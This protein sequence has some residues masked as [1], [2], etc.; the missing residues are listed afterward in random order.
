MAAMMFGGVHQ[1]LWF[2]IVVGVVAIVFTVAILVAWNVIFTR[3]YLLSTGAITTDVGTSHWLMLAVG[4]LFLLGIITILVLGVIAN[5]RQVLYMRLQKTFIDSVTHELKSPL[6]SIR[7]GLET[8]EMREMDPGT[9][10][11]FIQMMQHDVDRLQAFIEHIL[12][13]GRLEQGEIIVEPRPTQLPQVVEHCLRQIRRRHTHIDEGA[14]T[15]TWAMSDPSRT[16]ITD[17]VA[18][19]VVLNNLIDNAIKY[20]DP[21][22]VRVEVRVLDA[23]RNRIAIE[24]SDHGVG[25]EQKQLKRVFRRFYRVSGQDRSS[26]RGTGLGLYVVRNLVERMGGRVSAHSDGEGCGSTFR[27][28]IPAM[29]RDRARGGS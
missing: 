27:V 25:L 3:Y 8:M 11:R 6:A 17:P 13:A 9:R 1:R 10:L 22:D 24:V 5:V 20:S 28:Q 21:D 18:L 29:M 26:V 15:V 4:C 2:P 23:P 7:L 19:E 16:V 14:F 12:E